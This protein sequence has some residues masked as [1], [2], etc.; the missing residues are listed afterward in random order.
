M[1][2]TELEFTQR[3]A[4]LTAMN[5]FATRMIAALLLGL[6]MAVAAPV[7]PKRVLMLHSFGPDFGDEYSKDLRAEI[8]RRLPGEAR[9]AAREGDAAFASYLKTLFTDRPLDLV[10]TLGAPAADFV[11]KYRESLFAATPVLLTD[12]EERR[13]AG[14]PHGSNDTAVP[15]AVDISALAQDILQV[16]PQTTR[17]FV[18]IGNPPI[19]RYWMRQIDASLQAF[20]NRVSVVWLTDLPFNDLLERVATLPPRS[21]IL[22][23]LVSPEVVGV[24]KDED[25]ALAKLHQAADAPIFTYL[26]AY[27]PTPDLAGLRDVLADIQRDEHRAS[28]VIRRLR[29][30]L[31]KAPR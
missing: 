9:F 4:P 22:F 5:T 27:A 13:V 28:E 26:D 6:A 1:P 23:T 25:T 17:M 10:V 29:R 31:A 20:S 15:F 21:V 30:L 12:I 7:N 14:A 8:D 24:P 18:V 11:E 19:E 3:R 2:G 16:L